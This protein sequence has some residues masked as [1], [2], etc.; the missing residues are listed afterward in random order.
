MT[1]YLGYD[2]GTTNTLVSQY[3]ISDGPGINI[4]DR[5]A[6]AINDNGELVL[7]P[8]RAL[9]GAEIDEEKAGRY[10]S[11]LTD[12]IFKKVF[13]QAKKRTP[14]FMT[15]TVPNAFNDVQCKLMLDT[16]RAKCKE[17]TETSLSRSDT[18]TFIPEP[19]AAALYYVYSQSLD[20][21]SSG[22][23][24]VCDIGGGTTDLAIVKY[25]TET[26]E[27]GSKVSFKVICSLGKDM[28]GGDDID[29][30]IIDDLIHRFLLNETQYSKSTI[31]AGAR[32]LKRKLS[33]HEEAE[34][35]LTSPDGKTPAVDEDGEIIQLKMTR[36]RLERLLKKKNGFFDRFKG[37]AELFKQEFKKRFPEEYQDRDIDS[38]LRACT[39]L[40]IGGTS[41]IPCLRALMQ[42]CFLGKMYLLPG[43]T[44]DED[45]Y[46]PYDSVVRGA[47]IYSAWRANALEGVSEIV[48]EERTLHRI[49]ILTDRKYLETIVERNMPS[50]SYSPT[51][52][53]KPMQVD[54]GGKSF[55][56]KQIDLYEGEGEFVGDSRCGRPPVHIKS[57]SKYLKNLNDTIYIHEPYDSNSIPIFVT[58]NISQGRLESLTIQVPKGEEDMSD[59]IKH[60]DFVK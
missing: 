34:A 26:G 23:L 39:I 58:L 28:L 12:D 57:I 51:R 32:A 14:F 56:I 49:S 25:S 29:E 43:E 18:V 24:V 10:L 19:V 20:C 21:S 4:M 52:R 59:Y 31:V 9:S 37:L 2:Y 13:P 45:G 47:A 60:I 30:V 42:K 22:L 40:P 16:V 38:V 50:R 46:A 1:R 55:Q 35:I 53:L 41:Q 48:I 17:Y 7:S 15:L 36:E 44:S 11:I 8:K 3:L 27:N 33:I 54:N 6:S 5:R